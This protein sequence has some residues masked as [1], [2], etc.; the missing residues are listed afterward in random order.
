MVFRDIP[1]ERTL[2]PIPISR[3]TV[4]QFLT[5]MDR[6]KLLLV[7]SRVELLYKNNHIDGAVNCTLADIKTGSSQAISVFRLSG[8]KDIYVY[9]TSDECSTSSQV[10]EYMQY[11][12]A[13]S[14]HIIEGGLADLLM[15]LSD[16]RK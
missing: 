14:I 13:R 5:E 4:E 3:V 9:C 8:G 16:T 6:E 12:P 11:W 1:E 7:D 15:A 2:I 10:A